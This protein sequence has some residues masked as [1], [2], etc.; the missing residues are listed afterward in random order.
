MGDIFDQLASGQRP[1]QAT[2]SQ[3]TSP[4]PVANTGGDIFDQLASGQNSTSS[5]QSPAPS[6]DEL[7]FNPND[8]L[9]TTAGKAVSGAFEGIGEGVFGTAAGASDILDRVTG[10][11]PG[12]VNRGL[13]NLAGDNNTEHGGAQSVGLGAEYLGEYLLGDAALKALPLSERLLKAGRMA[14]IVE[15]SPVLNRLV[16]AGIRA[17]RGGAIGF[18][19]GEAKTGGDTSAA[20]GNAGMGAAGEAVVPEAF[21]AVKAGVKAVAKPFSLKAVQAALEG[22]KAEIQQSLQS[23]LQAVEDGWHG[24]IRKLFDTVADEAGVQ[25]KPAESLRD[26]AANTAQAVKAKAQSLYKQLDEALGGTRF[27]TFDEQISN[28]RKALRNSAGID[29]DADGRLI[30]R[31]NDLED[32][33]AKALEQ[34][35]AKGVNPNLINDANKTYRQASALEDLSK[36]IQ[37]STSGLRGDIAQGV[38]AAKE[39]VSP[40]KLSTRVNRLFN[41]GRLQQGLGQDH[42]E[43][44]LRAVETT[45]QSMQDAAENAARQTEAAEQK[46]VQQK[47]NVNTRRL[48]AGGVATALGVPR[49][50]TYL[51]HLLGE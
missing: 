10:M 26:V 35:E 3:S 2:P 8:N 4:T 12:A 38:N 36:H 50:A 39:S 18:A 7:R 48:I 46:A 41:T 5:A 43:N 44:L 45:K 15:E 11:K 33:K 31:I 17:V 21:D 20:L 14:K 6:S 13:H 19:Q 42:A 23:N 32:A 47:G 29:P 28:V 9:L 37:S 30:E 27:Q 16:Q 22:S 40:A 51:S 49:L 1:A 34:A 24:T 25:P